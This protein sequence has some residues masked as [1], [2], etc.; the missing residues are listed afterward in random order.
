VKELVERHGGR[1]AVEGRAKGSRFVV[2]LPSLPQRRAPHIETPPQ[3][4]A[5]VADHRSNGQ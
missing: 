2:V 1:V 4:L 3:V 5:G